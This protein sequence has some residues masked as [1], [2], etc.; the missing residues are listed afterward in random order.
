ML[1]GEMTHISRPVR[2]LVVVVVACA[3]CAAC[4]VGSIP[5]ALDSFAYLL[6]SHFVLLFAQ[7]DGRMRVRF[8]HVYRAWN[9]M[10]DGR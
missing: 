5:F 7:V 3:M 1:V 8:S 10:V 2:T 4:T 6:V 9:A